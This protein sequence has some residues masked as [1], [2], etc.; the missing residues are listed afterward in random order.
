MSRPLALRIAV[1]MALGLFLIQSGKGEQAITKHLDRDG[2]K[3]ITF[4]GKYPIAEVTYQDPAVPV[5]VELEAFSPFI[6]LDLENSIY[7]ATVLTYRVTNTSD[8]KVSGELFGWL[9]NAVC[10]KSR[11]NVAGR[12]RNRVVHM[13]QL[14]REL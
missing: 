1:L 6:P 9:E 10:I 2:F 7:P 13:P 14:G 12:L 3:D 8:R 4:R 5:R 11:H